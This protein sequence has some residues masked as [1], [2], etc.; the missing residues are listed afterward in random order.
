M[1][2]YRFT[3][4]TE[5]IFTTTVCTLKNALVVPLEIPVVFETSMVQPALTR[6]LEGV[7]PVLLFSA[8]G[9][10]GA[11]DRIIDLSPLTIVA[12]YFFT[13]LPL[14]MCFCSESEGFIFI[15]KQ[16]QCHID[17]DSFIHT[18]PGARVT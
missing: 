5:D 7:E 2:Q 9:G 14:C 3:D 15:H 11:E 1:K 6:A 13:P 4:R 18:A 8:S 16:L 17:I 10:Q 12:L